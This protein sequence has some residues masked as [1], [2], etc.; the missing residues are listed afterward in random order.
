LLREDCAL[1]IKP[2]QSCV[3][4][5]QS[6]GHRYFFFSF[7]PINLFPGRGSGGELRGRAEA[8]RER[9]PMLGGPLRPAL[10]RAGAKTLP[11]GKGWAMP[12][13][14][15]GRQALVSV[16][17]LSLVPQQPPSPVPL[18]WAGPTGQGWGQSQKHSLH[19]VWPALKREVHTT[20]TNKLSQSHCRIRSLSTSLQT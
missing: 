1:L 6:G 12:L 14:D 15:G 13:C 17:E 11:S 19:S 8:K 10:G 2:H 5:W 7:P 16:T 3:Y 4:S 18:E 9:G 20:H